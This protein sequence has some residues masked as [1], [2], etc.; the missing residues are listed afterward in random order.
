[1]KPGAVTLKTN[2]SLLSALY[3]AGGPTKW[4]DLAK[5]QVLGNDTKTTYDVGS[6]VRGDTSQNPQLKDGGVV[7]VPEGRKV[8]AKGI[9][10][11]ILSGVGALWLLK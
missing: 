2:F 10:Q 3:A 8:D 5:V 9:F 11:T 1:D 7:F 6:L 4:A